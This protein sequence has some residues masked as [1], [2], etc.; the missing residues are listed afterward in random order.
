MKPWPAALSDTATVPSAEEIEASPRW[1]V[2]L[3]PDAF[4][5]VTDLFLKVEFQGDIARLSAAG[6][7]LTDDFYNGTPWCI[8]LRRFRRQVE[9]GDMEIAIVPWRD[10]SDVILD[11]P[12]VNR[13]GDHRARLLEMSVL[14]EY[15][16]TV[17]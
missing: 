8:G 7:L 5:G 11:G 3:P 10:R 16:L 2:H 4:V 9:S 1:R 17:P 6:R 15:E 12:A 14:P 13:S